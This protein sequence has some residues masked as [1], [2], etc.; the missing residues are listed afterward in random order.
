MKDIRLLRLILIFALSSPLIAAARVGETADESQKRYGTATP[1]AADQLILS[2]VVN[3]V[4]SY[5]GWQITAA[6][7]DAKTARI[8]Y[9]KGRMV[10]E[11]VPKWVQ[12]AKEAGLLSDRQAKR[13]AEIATKLSSRPNANNTETVSVFKEDPVSSDEAKTILKSES[14]VGN[15]R[16]FDPK[17]Q[18]RNAVFSFSAKEVPATLINDFGIVAH[19]TPTCVTLE[20]LALIQEFEKQNGAPKEPPAAIPRF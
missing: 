6:Y 17:T 8:R 7:V 9:R 12:N 13:R 1:A 18:S 15:W 11:S 4:F 2:N 20:K 19:I 10:E 16:E 5:M 14:P 3:Q